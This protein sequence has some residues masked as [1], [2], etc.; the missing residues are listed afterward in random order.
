MVLQLVAVNLE[1]TLR[2]LETEFVDGLKGDAL[3]TELV[4]LLLGLS[5]PLSRA[6][7]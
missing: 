3:E 4:L 7:R 6:W 1:V 2:F 5:D